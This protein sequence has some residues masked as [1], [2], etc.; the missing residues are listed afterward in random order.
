LLIEHAGGDGGLF[1]LKDAPLASS[2]D[3][4]ADVQSKVSSTDEDDATPDVRIIQRYANCADSVF[5]SNDAPE[6]SDA[7]KIAYGSGNDVVKTC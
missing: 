5:Y 1:C 4:C 7:W 6:Q 3:W 2:R